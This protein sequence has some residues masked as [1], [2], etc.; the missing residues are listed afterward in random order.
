MSSFVGHSLTGLTTYAIAHPW[1]AD[2]EPTRDRPD[3]FWLFWLL[4]VASIPDIDHLIT[5]LRIQ[6]ENGNI[7]TTHSFVGTLILPILTIVALWFWGQRGKVFAIKSVQVVVLGLSH[8]LLDLL[9]GVPSLA[10][11]YPFSL[12]TF[13]LPFGLLPSAGQ[14]HPLNYYLYR[15]LFIEVGVLIPFF[16]S[17][18]LS[19][20]TIPRLLNRR[21]AIASG[22]FVSAC[23]A[24]WAA[25][26]SR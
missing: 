15:N 22:F 13:K 20:R 4:V 12:E 21:F 5:V 11:F 10:L 16:A 23:F 17:L 18:I 24:I 6:T 7:R 3:W 9:T 26:L 14:L 1:K 2:R 8:L 25:S 19:V